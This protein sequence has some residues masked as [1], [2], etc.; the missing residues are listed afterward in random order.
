MSTQ[1]APIAGNQFVLPTENLSGQLNNL[2]V[3]SEQSASIAVNSL[4]VSS[5]VNSNLKP[6]FEGLATQ[7]VTTAANVT[8]AAGINLNDFTGAAAQATTLP[9]AVAGTVVVHA[10][11]LDTA[12]GV[13]TLTFD[14]AGNDVFETGS[15]IRTTGGAPFFSTSTAGQTLLTFTPAN[16]NTNL[17]TKGCFIYF[18]CTSAGKWHVSSDLRTVGSTGTFGFSA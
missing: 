10:Q 17:L 7:D 3:A 1:T 8:Y 5:S 14:C 13:L 9:A 16:A 2:N 15:V 11:A 4:T 6:S 18:I 12:G